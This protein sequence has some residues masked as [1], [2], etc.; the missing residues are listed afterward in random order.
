M[1][2]IILVLGMMLT[3]LGCV[4]Q[5]QESSNS[6]SDK[7][8]Y[9]EV[10]FGIRNKYDGE[11]YY[12]CDIRKDMYKIN[13]QTKKLEVFDIDCS[14]GKNFDPSHTDFFNFLE[15]KVRQN[16]MIIDYT[17]LVE[18]GMMLQ[19]Y[20]Q[21][22]PGTML[23]RDEVDTLSLFIAPN[24]DE[25]YNYIPEGF[26]KKGIDDPTDPRLEEFKK[27]G[28]ARGWT[29][30]IER[31][32]FFVP[33]NNMNLDN[34]CLSD[35][36]TMSDE[37]GIMGGFECG[38]GLLDHQDEIERIAENGGFTIYDVVSKEEWDEYKRILQKCR[39]ENV[40]IGF[41]IIWKDKK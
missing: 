7:Y 12:N 35:S 25:T 30:F 2:K 1:K 15:N 38:Q 26:S 16:K 17:Y 24:H 20:L 34:V 14:N 39:D 3:I 40:N 8:N 27:A 9:N 5:G 32:E 19:N 18:H 4:A 21:D 31:L 33:N 23:T 10:V 41:R 11:S 36:I 13:K 37:S 29:A 22:N 28:Y 6:S